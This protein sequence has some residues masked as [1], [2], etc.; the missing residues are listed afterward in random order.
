MQGNGCLALEGV[1]GVRGCKGRL[2]QGVMLCKACLAWLWVGGN[3]AKGVAGL[4][5]GVLVCG[6]QL[7]LSVL[8]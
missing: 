7:G 4:G 5:L 3:W 8:G 6:C 2:L 1:V